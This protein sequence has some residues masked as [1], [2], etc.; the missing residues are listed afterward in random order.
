MAQPDQSQKL[1][2]VIVKGP[3]A[4]I[5]KQAVSLEKVFDAILESTDCK[6]TKN[7]PVI[8]ALFSIFENKEYT[9]PTKEE[10]I[11]Y[12][13]KKHHDKFCAVTPLFLETVIFYKPSWTK[14]ILSLLKTFDV[15]TA[16]KVENICGREK[17]SNSILDIALTCCDVYVISAIIE[18]KASISD[19]PLPIFKRSGLSFDEKVAMLMSLERKFHILPTCDWFYECV[20]HFPDTEGRI[21]M[22]ELGMMVRAIPSGDAISASF[23]AYGIRDLEWFCNSG[24]SPKTSPEFLGTL[25]SNL[26]PAKKIMIIERLELEGWK[27]T[28]N[29]YAKASISADLALLEYLGKRGIPFTE[30][31]MVEAYKGLF[32]HRSNDV[33][34]E[35]D[36]STTYP[37]D[38][39][40][41][42][43]GDCLR[44]MAE[45]VN[46]ASE[47]QNCHPV[48][49][50]WIEESFHKTV[51]TLKGLGPLAPLNTDA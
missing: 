33:A 38:V 8:L 36:D 29:A 41:C 1:D 20:K 15:K 27:I 23:T 9:T 6:G 51:W 37:K 22:Y 5:S 11:P 42:C 17:R 44:K 24:F 35:K 46:L 40:W 19:Y 28:G 3:N 30:K 48:M 2:V 7:Q 16:N 47:Y 10:F 14:I 31:D 13:V 25:P 21:V 39:E 43:V 12:I 34:I 45:P 4:P 49:K 26:K 50:K 18:Q 32:A